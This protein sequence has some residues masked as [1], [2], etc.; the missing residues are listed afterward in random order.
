M[1]LLVGDAEGY[2][3]AIFYTIIYVLMS[4]AVFGILLCTARV[5]RPIE[6]LV[7][8]Q[9]LSKT[10][11]WMAFLMLLLMFSMAGI[12]LTIGFYAKLNI[13]Q[14]VIGDGEIILA[15]IAVV[16]SV[17]G[18]YYY[19][20]VV[21]LMYFDEDQ[22]QSLVASLPTGNVAVLSV[23]SL[24]VVALFIS[25]QFLMELCIRSLG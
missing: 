21:K 3:A 6:A 4:S 22:Q 24:L 17:I 7:D 13:L 1:G 20:R 25:P 5:N 19:L 14:V 18:A 15:A 10:Y 11:P 23:H 12:P 16:S 2:S 8:L 9:G